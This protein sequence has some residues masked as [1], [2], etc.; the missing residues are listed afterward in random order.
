MKEMRT[1]DQGEGGVTTTDPIHGADAPLPGSHT[2]D[3][4]GPMRL[5]ALIVTNAPGSCLATVYMYLI[6]IVIFVRE[7]ISSLVSSLIVYSHLG[8]SFYYG[9]LAL[10][11]LDT[12][13]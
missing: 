11:I 3:G 6:S 1:S 8:G 5:F 12:G 13:T 7:R 4:N 2:G 10:R 9:S